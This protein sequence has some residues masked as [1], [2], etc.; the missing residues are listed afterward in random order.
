MGKLVASLPEKGYVPMSSG[1]RARAPSIT[2]EADGF[3]AARDAIR[4]LIV[5]VP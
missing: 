1:V 2:P 4:L 3:L 5:E